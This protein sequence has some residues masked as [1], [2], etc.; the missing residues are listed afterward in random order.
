[1]V[2]GCT[3]VVPG[4]IWIHLSLDDG[5]RFWSTY[6]G[7]S[8]FRNMFQILTRQNTF[9]E[10]RVCTFVHL[11][12]LMLKPVWC[13]RSPGCFCMFLPQC[14]C[15][16]FFAKLICFVGNHRIFHEFPNPCVFFTLVHISPTDICGHHR[17]PGRS[18]V[19]PTHPRRSRNLKLM[20][21][22]QGMR[23]WNR[24]TE[25]WRGEDI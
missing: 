6:I 4:L 3:H 22:H 16:F 10:C 15:L 19:Q 21:Y 2:G 1:M 24:G 11:G 25:S 9:V 14:S 12:H 18:F 23:P 8:K 20:I 5:L 7:S 13:T 17:H